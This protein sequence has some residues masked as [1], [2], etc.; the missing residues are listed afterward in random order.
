MK[1]P[2]RVEIVEVGPRDG[3]QSVARQYP[4]EIKSAMI[5]ALAAT[6]LS[7]VEATSFMRPE[8]VPQLADAEAVWAGL[9]RHPGCTYRALVA[10]RRGMERAVAAGVEEV[11][12]LATAS[13]RYVQMNQNTG[14]DGNLAALES[15]VDAAPGGSVRFVGAIAMSIFCAYEGPV[16]IDRTL[17]IVRRYRELGVTEVSLAT[18]T[19]VEGPAE[20]HRLVAEVLDVYPELKVGVHL[21]NANG[22]ALANA[23]AAMQAGATVLESSI[24][25]MGGG[26]RLPGGEQDHGNVA[27]EDLVHLCFELGV[28]TGVSLPAL[29]EA[30]KEIEGLLGIPFKSY[31]ARGATKD[32]LMASARTT[33][34]QGR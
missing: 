30:S 33:G 1:L 9:K 2:S 28:E 21:H 31:A 25:G 8:M 34:W 12:L 7:R 13:E 18:S 4:S 29:L 23:L 26:I 22:M 20:V 15:A 3:L 14:V 17:A 27:T 11:V 6:G 16:S 5:D 24:G 10:N 32:G 19:G